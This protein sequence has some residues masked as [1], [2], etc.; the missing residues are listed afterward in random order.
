MRLR[1][2]ALLLGLATLAPLGC[3]CCRPCDSVPP[4]PPPCPLQASPPPLAS[5]IGM[6]P[7]TDPDRPQAEPPLN[8]ARPTSL[9]SWTR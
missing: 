6:L 5:P 4:P 2:A 9:T 3:K 7:T 1:F 8:S